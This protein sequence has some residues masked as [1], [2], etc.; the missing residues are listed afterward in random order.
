MIIL[1]ID[2]ALKSTGYAVCEALPFK[3]NKTAHEGWTGPQALSKIPNLEHLISGRLVPKPNRG[4]VTQRIISI[5]KQLRKIREEFAWRTDKVHILIELPSKHV[6]PYRHGGG[7][8]GLANYG[9]I[10]GALWREYSIF[11][12]N[13]STLTV[14]DIGA[15]EWLKGAYQRAKNRKLI[16]KHHFPEYDPAKDKGG[17]AADACCLIIWAMKFGRL[18]P[19]QSP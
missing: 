11:S 10:C 6:N 13:R 1:G 7:G 5:A 8:S 19:W 4:P 9:L 12:E 18:E 2:P 17:D 3:R 16:A 14:T 15:E